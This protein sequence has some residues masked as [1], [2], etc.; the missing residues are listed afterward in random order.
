MRF[1][2]NE[3]LIGQTIPIIIDTSPSLWEGRRSRGGN[4]V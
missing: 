3:N 4:G 1:W 2:K